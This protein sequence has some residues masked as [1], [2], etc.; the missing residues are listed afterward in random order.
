MLLEEL[1]L[2]IRSTDPEMVLTAP[3]IGY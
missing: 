3:M 2:K 1:I